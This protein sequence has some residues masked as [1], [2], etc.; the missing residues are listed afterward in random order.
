MKSLLE[1]SGTRQMAGALTRGGAAEARVL[2]RHGV[3]ARPNG[4]LAA[5]GYVLAAPQRLVA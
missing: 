1:V 5:D 3:A 2:L 4:I